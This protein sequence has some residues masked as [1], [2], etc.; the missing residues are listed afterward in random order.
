[1]RAEG[2]SGAGRATT[3]VQP[4]SAEEHANGPLDRTAVLKLLQMV[5]IHGCVCLCVH[6][7]VTFFWVSA[8]TVI[9]VFYWWIDRAFFLVDS[10]LCGCINWGEKMLIVS[11]L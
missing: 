3:V 9:Q 1:M 8:S 2:V 5:S 10:I 11:T 7:F 4:T 6:S